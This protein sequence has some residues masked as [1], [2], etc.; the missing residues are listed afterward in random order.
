MK[1][2]IGFIKKITIILLS[3]VFSSGCS[4]ALSN[5]EKDLITFISSDPIIREKIENY[6]LSQTGVT[7]N[8]DYVSYP[9][10]K[11]YQTDRIQLKLVTVTNPNISFQLILN[12]KNKE[13]VTNIYNGNITSMKDTYEQDTKRLYLNIIDDIYVKANVDTYSKI[14]KDKLEY[15]DVKNDFL[16]AYFDIG[17]INKDS[18]DLK[19]LLDTY[20]NPDSIS[21]LSINDINK[22][23]F[24]LAILEPVHIGDWL[25]SEG[26]QISIDV[27]IIEDDI[28]TDKAIDDLVNLIQN[29]LELLPENLIHKITIYRKNEPRVKNRTFKF[30]RIGSNLTVDFMNDNQ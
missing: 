20:N 17:Y 18:N 10:I 8:L 23:V 28:I 29:N 11:T 26:S 24:N 19:F 12:T 4:V 21:N 7:F 1:N 2:R 3:I 6:A 14:F 9:L 5:D 16:R 22:S 15:L 30:V 13:D 27:E 25:K